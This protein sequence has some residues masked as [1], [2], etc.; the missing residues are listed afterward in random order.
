MLEHELSKSQ[1]KTIGSLFSG[2][3]YR[4]T[5]AISIDGIILIL[6]RF[7][8]PQMVKARY[9]IISP[10]MA[11]TRGFIWFNYSTLSAFLQSGSRESW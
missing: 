5:G 10:I 11:K 6:S 9:K 7:K 1:D 3:S 2:T 8:F 4:S